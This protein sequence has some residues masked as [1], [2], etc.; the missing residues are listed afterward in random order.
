MPTVASDCFAQKQC[1]PTSHRETSI[2]RNGMREAAT[3][4]QVS[5]SDLIDQRSK[6]QYV[7]DA[8]MGL[9]CL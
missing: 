3:I 9:S 7:A 8:N 1:R 2:R 6:L 4:L 5:L